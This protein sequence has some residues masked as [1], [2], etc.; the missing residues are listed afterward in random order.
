[1][2]RS[3]FALKG[4]ME[5]IADTQHLPVYIMAVLIV[6][7]FAV[8]LSNRLLYKRQQEVKTQARQLNTQ[9]GLVLTSSKTQ[10]WTFD[11]IKNHYTLLSNDGVEK[12]YTPIDF[13]QFFDSNDFGKLHKAVVSL[14]DSEEATQPIVIKGPTP[15]D[16]SMAHL[17]KISLNVLQRDKK[18]KARILLGAQRDITEDTARK[19]KTRNLA[20]RYHT[21]F[22][23]SL[24][25]MVFYDANGVLSDINEKACETFGISSR[26]QLMKRKVR[27]TDVPAYKELDFNHLENLQM[28]SVTDIDRTKRDDERIPEITVGGK[29]YYECDVT[30]IRDNDNRLNGI[31]TAGRNITDM[32]DSHHR[33]QRDT[34]LLKKRTKEI[35]EYINNINYSLKVSGVRLVNYHPDNHELE[36]FSDLNQVQYSLPQIRCITLV[37]L[38]DRRKASGLLFRMDR[39]TPG[40]FTSTLQTCLHDEQG[41]HVYLTFSMV[42]VVGKDGIISHYFGMLRNETEMAY[43]ELQLIKETEKAQETEKL[44][45]TFLLNMSYEIRTPLNAVIGFAELFNGPHDVEDEPVFSEEIKRNTNELLA[46]VNDILYISRL[47]AKMVEFNYQETDFAALFDGFCYMGWSMLAPG[48]KVQVENPYN[49]LMVVIDEQHLGEIIS[50]LCVHA[51]GATKTG[52][53]R[54][55]YDYRHGELNITFEDS[56]CGVNEKDLPHVFDR[57]A[58]DKDNVRH[59]TGLDM[60]II[61]ELVEQMGGSIEIQSEEGKGTVVYLIIPCKRTFMERKEEAV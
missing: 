53:I 13:A 43:T 26:D 57:F 1:M 40:N 52:F 45:N 3:A 50:K 9:L 8:I 4:N 29:M 20:M 14:P 55:K 35:Q 48:V 6:C 36:I 28:V 5:T 42:P 27:I 59:G 31:I 30:P 18:G 33:Q 51:A 25:D 58:R 49:H 24:V 60:S 61:K 16:G 41:R 10:V 11:I 56:G 37:A 17:Y 12:S 22:Y 2:A 38:P 7:V 21:I 19:E 44:K 54:A 46:L 39:R 32:V 15:E 47:D 34:L 23:S